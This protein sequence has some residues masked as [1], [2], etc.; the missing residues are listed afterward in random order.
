MLYADESVLLSQGMK[1]PE[2]VLR[3]ALK[4]KGISPTDLGR[5]LGYKNPYQAVHS[6]M[7]GRRKFG[8]ELQERVADILGLPRDHFEAPDRTAA[9][10]LY[11]HKEFQKFLLTDIGRGIDDETRRTLAGMPFTGR[12][13]PTV[14]LYQAIALS[15]RGD[16]TT[17]EIGT[18]I[19]LNEP[20]DVI[21]AGKA[22]QIHRRK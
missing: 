1:T 8:R 13:L 19:V 12:R 20:L 22:E 11:I 7:V 15:M 9:R 3:E 18:D 14:A 2:E 17:E 5:Q 4:T 16:H 21:N 10:E 6:L